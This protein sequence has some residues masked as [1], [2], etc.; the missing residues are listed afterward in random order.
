VSNSLVAVVP[1]VGNSD[2]IAVANA[3]ADVLLN[4]DYSHRFLFPWTN[5]PEGFQN[6]LYKQNLKTYLVDGV[7]LDGARSIIPGVGGPFMAIN[8]P[9]G[10]DGAISFP[11]PNEWWG[12]FWGQMYTRDCPVRVVG[13][14][15]ESNVVNWGFGNITQSYWN[16][17]YNDAAVQAARPTYMTPYTAD[18][19]WNQ[20][21]GAVNAFNKW[22][23]VVRKDAQRSLLVDLYVNN[24]GS[25]PEIVSDW[26]DCSASNVIDPNGWPLPGNR[27]SDTS[28]PEVYVG[29]WDWRNPAY[30]HTS[31]NVDGFW[32]RFIQCRNN[33]SRT[34]AAGGKVVPWIP[35]PRWSD[36]SWPTHPAIQ[37]LQKE[38]IRHC[39]AMGVDK[40]IYWNPVA[41]TTADDRD[42]DHTLS[43]DL[44][45]SLRS[46]SD[47]STSADTLQTG[48]VVTRFAD[49]ALLWNS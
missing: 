15:A 6:Y 34:I 21:P 43:Y 16:S 47:A 44:Y 1:D 33:I 13:L 48:D 19:V 31:P 49:Y 25:E 32:Y 41:T 45:P 9:V 14:D 17:V 2:A 24:F 18:D 29:W 38:L 26:Q 39:M 36:Q 5:V 3:A 28:S 10:V 23:D 40:F 7:N 35:P 27:I 11:T 42:I 37:F 4:K 46:F 30:L 22:A 8:Y 12:N 20:V